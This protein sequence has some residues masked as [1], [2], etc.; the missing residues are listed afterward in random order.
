MAK[1]E[2]DRLYFIVRSALMSQIGGVLYLAG[3]WALGTVNFIQS[4]VWGVIVFTLA[5]VISRLFDPAIGIAVVKILKFMRRHARI[6]RFVLKY[7]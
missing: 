7:F 6:K 1:A 2:N 4:L 5:M 3:V